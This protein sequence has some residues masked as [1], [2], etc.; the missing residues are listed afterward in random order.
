VPFELNSYL[1]VHGLGS[2]DSCAILKVSFGVHKFGPRVSRD[3]QDGVALNFLQ[4]ESKV[5]IIV[6]AM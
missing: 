4:I 6:N 3:G 5:V 1:K 2:I